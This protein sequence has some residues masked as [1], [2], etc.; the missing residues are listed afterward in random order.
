LKSKL[1]HAVTDQYQRTQ[2]SKKARHRPDNKDKPSA[3]KPI[4]LT[5]KRQHKL[6]VKQYLALAL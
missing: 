5:A 3:G 1:R 4:I 2:E 6:N